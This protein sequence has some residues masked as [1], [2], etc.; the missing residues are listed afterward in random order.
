MRKDGKGRLRV[1]FAEFEGNDATIQEGLRSIAQA[2]NKTFEAKTKIVKILPGEGP[3]G[4]PALLDELSEDLDEKENDGD[5]GT[6]RTRAASRGKR[7]SPTLRIVTDLDLRPEGRQSLRDFFAEKGPSKQPEMVAVFVYYLQTI[8]E[9][10]GITPNH[11]FT[12]FKDVGERC[13]GDLLKAIRT[14]ASDKG[15]V[16][17]AGQKDITITNLGENFVEHDLAQETAAE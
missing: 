7:K 15:W 5:V 12:C 10:S 16:E 2:V 11:V 13:P 14:A 17:P 9:V 8:L 1:F 3:D 4:D 6:G